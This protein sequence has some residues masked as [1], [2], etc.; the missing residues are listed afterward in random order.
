MPA[1]R[2]HYIN[3][4]PKKMLMCPF[5]SAVISNNVYASNLIVFLLY[6]PI[7]LCKFIKE[8]AHQKE[9]FVILTHQYNVFIVR[10][11]QNRYF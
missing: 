5:F 6:T 3:R 1:N 7:S 8:N 10:E 2:I 4:Q 9:A 11:L